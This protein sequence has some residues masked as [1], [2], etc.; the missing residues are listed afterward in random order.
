MSFDYFDELFKDFERLEAELGELEQRAG[1]KDES[2]FAAVPIFA[3]VADQQ[4]QQRLVDFVEP[5]KQHVN[6]HQVGKSL[7][8]YEEVVRMQA[9][10]AIIVPTSKL[11]TVKISRQFYE[12]WIEG[13][14]DRE[15]LLETLET[16]RD[17]NRSAQ[18]VVKHEQD[19]NVPLEALQAIYGVM[20]DFKALGFNQ[21][22]EFLSQVADDI[23]QFEEFFGLSW[24][25]THYNRTHKNRRRRFLAALRHVIPLAY[26]GGLRDALSDLTVGYSV[27]EYDGEYEAVNLFEQRIAFVP[28][29]QL[30]RLMYEE[31]KMKRYNERR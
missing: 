26:S 13:M 21:L 4:Q 23:E 2:R 11:A 3:N 12:N 7:L 24:F 5:P 19:G 22:W 18:A 10:L 31:G 6:S 14:Y 17:V 27:E 28:I 29:T 16:A 15:S 9:Q 25:E 1:R 8:V 30:S 20:D